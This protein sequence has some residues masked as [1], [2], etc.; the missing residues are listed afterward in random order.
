M[1]NIQLLID[2]YRDDPS[3]VFVFPSEVCAGFWREHSTRGKDR[4]SVRKQQ[5]IS[6][7]SFKEKVL[8]RD[9]SRR[10]ANSIIRLIFAARQLAENKQ[11]GLFLSIV[12]PEYKWNSPAFTDYIAGILPS[13][14]IFFEIFGT[15]TEDLN[16][17]L[18]KDLE[19]LYTGY[20]AF[21]DKHH[22][23]EPSFERQHL[24]KGN[25]NYFILFSDV[26]DD[27]S[28]YR[29]II[30]TAPGVTLITAGEDEVSAAGPELLRYDTAPLEIRDVLFKIAG[31]LES[32]VHPSEIVVSVAQLDLL[33]DYIKEQARL[34]NVPLSF[35]GGS[36]L[37]KFSAGRLFSLV[38]NCVIDSFSL[39]SMRALLLTPAVPW[40]D[41]ALGRSL[42]RLGIAGGCFRNY[43]R[44]GAEVEVWER[45]FRSVGSQDPEGEIEKFYRDLKTASLRI[46]GAKSFALLRQ[47]ITA[48]NRDFLESDRWDPEELAVFQLSLDILRELTVLEEESGFDIDGPF[49]V[50]LK[51][52]R[53]RLYVKRESGH[54]VRVYPYRV[55][56]GIYPE[57]HFVICAS[58]NATLIRAESFP[59]LREVDRKKL[60]LSAENIT[61]NML[62]CYTGSGKKVIVSSAVLGFQGPQLLP[63]LFVA[64]ETPA[65]EP[66]SDDI[67]KS[68]PFYREE[69]S[70]GSLADLEGQPAPVQVE[71]YRRIRAT[72]LAVRGT[73]FTVTP[74]QSGS[75]RARV[76]TR[77]FGEDGTLALSNSKME[78]FLGCPYA[79]FLKRG[80]KIE[81]PDYSIPFEDPLSL[82]TLQHKIL[83]TIYRTIHEQDGAYKRDKVES[84]KKLFREIGGDLVRKWS[85]KHRYPLPHVLDIIGPKIIEEICTLSVTEAETFPG[86]LIEGTETRYEYIDTGL[87]IRFNGKID[88][89]SVNPD[90]GAALL[91]DYKKRNP[92]DKKRVAA[93]TPEGEEDALLSFQIPFYLFL[94]EKQGADVEGA[95]YYSIEKSRWDH[96]FS[97]TGKKA[98]TSKDTMVGIQSRMYELAGRM[99][100]SL[101]AGEFMA[102]Q[103]GCVPCTF[104]PICRMKYSIR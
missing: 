2:R 85:I 18:V 98:W 31:L 33:E 97:E 23:F 102:P 63:G 10:P 42:V 60:Q 93:I 1:K 4:P 64:G 50:W 21:L 51:V 86:Y 52:L 95:S 72:G 14:A 59:Y 28:H 56:A 16:V 43:R 92:P 88:R 36:K 35:R 57:H 25:A 101:R 58:H 40:K 73:N 81:E 9:P 103:G 87:D 19:V 83:E 15:K 104:R 79:F 84:Y 94:L 24:S 3:S 22:Y 38:S 39:N 66:R 90:T 68:D 96:V 75:V 67:R 61:E 13:L 77:L 55:T 20:R 34:Y 54:G 12:P 78:E 37:E 32:G 6:W 70:W 62:L 53:K 99:G 41:P 76:H 69:N 11:K 65:S 80:L 74:V 8:I 5:F 46:A 44:K 29:E 7:D 49:Q 48:F 91:I 30:E 71:G 17:L 27:F 26:I 100:A 89:V 47:T 45:S 82:G